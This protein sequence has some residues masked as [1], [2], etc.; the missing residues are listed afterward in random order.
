MIQAF[1]DFSPEAKV[2]VYQSNRVITTDEKKV[3]ELKANE[4]V[5]KWGTHGVPLKSKAA[6]VSPFHL[7][8]SVDGDVQASGCS[9]DSSVRFVKSVGNDL[10]IDFFDRLKSVMID[11]NEQMQ[12]VGFHSLKNFPENKVFHPAITTMNE[13]RNN[14]IVPIGEL[15]K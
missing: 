14:W 5:A 6:V 2:W 12:L 13:L 1:S 10:Q 3:I 15:V 7:V 4:F 8:L 9:I 11:E